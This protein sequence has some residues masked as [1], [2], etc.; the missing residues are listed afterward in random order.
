M[1]QGLGRIT[2]SFATLITF[3]SRVAENCDWF[4]DP[5][6]ENVHHKGAKMHEAPISLLLPNIP[7]SVLKQS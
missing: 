7:F 3:C 6:A 4:L 2:N 5:S 1:A